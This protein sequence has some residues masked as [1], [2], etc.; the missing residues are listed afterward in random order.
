M[1]KAA[2]EITAALV[3]AG[4]IALGT[5][6]L[7]GLVWLMNRHERGKQALPPRPERPRALVVPIHAAHVPRAPAKPPRPPPPF[8]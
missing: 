6:V 7:M 3:L 8:P 5:L 1:T 4:E 2:A